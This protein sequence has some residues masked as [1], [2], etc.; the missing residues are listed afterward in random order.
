MRNSAQH[1]V[2][3]TRDS[4]SKYNYTIA[5]HLWHY[6][7]YY[8]IFLNYNLKMRIIPYSTLFSLVLSICSTLYNRTLYTS[9]PHPKKR[10]AVRKVT[11]SLKK[12]HI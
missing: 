8:I 6:D 10:C 7:S 5:N 2:Y 4:I 3:I 1:Q 9:V 12:L 11:F